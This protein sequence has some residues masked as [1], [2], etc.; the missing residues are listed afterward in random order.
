MDI[1]CLFVCPSPYPKSYDNN[2]KSKNTYDLLITGIHYTAAFLTANNLFMM[3]F[4][5]PDIVTDLIQFTQENKCRGQ[6]EA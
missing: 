3:K 6:K 4:L 2:N 5:L 1:V